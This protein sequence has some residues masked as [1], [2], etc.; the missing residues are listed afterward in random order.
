M[1]LNL[2][3]LAILF[4][5]KTHP[6]ATTIDFLTDSL[7][8]KRFNARK[9][10][11]KA[12]MMCLSNLCLDLKTAGYLHRTA[13][14]EGKI[15]NIYAYRLTPQGEELVAEVA[16]HFCRANPSDPEPKPNAE[17]TSSWR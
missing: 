3:P 15:R 17:G 14:H 12:T 13:N 6:G 11:R 9:S 7:I 10:S 4:F 1:D 2:V 5:V 16:R 8:M